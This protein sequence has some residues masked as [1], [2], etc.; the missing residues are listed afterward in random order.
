MLS[1]RHRFALGALTIAAAVTIAGCGRKVTETDVITDWAQPSTSVEVHETGGIGGFVTD[2][3]VRKETGAFFFTRRH[4]CTTAT[5][6]PALD[7]AR[8][9]LSAS[10]TAAL[11]A[12]VVADSA[13]LSAADFGS[14]HSAADMIDYVVRV[15]S[16]GELVIDARGDDGTMPPP[17][18]R[19]VQA[20][21]A[22]ISDARK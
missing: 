8:G 5:C 16:F 9:T 10:A 13:G 7:S 11:F 15:R 14:T 19:I 3:A 12:T 18:R 20:V 22:A 6:P 2:Y 1:A 21:H 17:M 4:A